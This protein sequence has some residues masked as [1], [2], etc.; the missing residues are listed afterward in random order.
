MSARIEF[1]G[2]F[3]AILVGVSVYF[4]E[5]PIDWPFFFFGVIAYLIVLRFLCRQLAKGFK[6]ESAARARTTG[7]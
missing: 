1:L 4:V 5:R 3:L 2:Y 7:Q 6:Y